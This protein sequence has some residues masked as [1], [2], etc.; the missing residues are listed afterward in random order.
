VTVREYAPSGI[1]PAST[2]ISVASCSPVRGV[3]GQSSVACAAW[4]AV[5]VRRPAAPAVRIKAMTLKRRR[6]MVAPFLRDRRT[7]CT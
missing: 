4:L 1:G 6:I 5:P 7:A 2:V 3:P